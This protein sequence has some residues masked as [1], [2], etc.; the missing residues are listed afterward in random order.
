MAYKKAGVNIDAGKT[1]MK[2]YSLILLATVISLPAMEV[3]TDREIAEE[4]T[5]PPASPWQQLP[6]NIQNVI[7]SMVVDNENVIVEKALNEQPRQVECLAYRPDGKQLA[8]GPR[9]G[10]IILW[11]SATGNKQHTLKG[12]EGLVKFLAYSPDGKQLA[13]AS[14]N[15]SI[16][17]W[18]PQSGKIIH[19]LKGDTD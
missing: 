13:T 3:V 19:K 1:S 10:R 8:S 7:L 5:D 4:K 14:Y 17:L 11:D 2:T 6:T 9:Y 12:R 15:S 16:F 18:D